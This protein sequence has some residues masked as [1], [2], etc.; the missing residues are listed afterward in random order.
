MD[1]KIVD[2]NFTE[3]IEDKTYSVT[4]A[5][6][7]LK[8]SSVKIN[9]IIFKI[10]R[11]D[12]D[13]VLIEDIN[14][15]TQS[16]LETI[17]LFETLHKDEGMSYEDVV[18]YFLKNSNNLLKKEDKTLSREITELD[19]KAIAKSLMM[20]SQKQ[21][22]MIIQTLKTDILSEIIKSFSEE[23]AK[24]GKATIEAMNI[25][26]QEIDIELEEKLSEFNNRVD[27]LTK[28]IEEKDK[29]LE[30]LYNEKYEKQDEDLRNKLNKMKNKYEEELQKEKEKTW[31][32]K[33]KDRFK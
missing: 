28:K 7:K 33:I 21:T 14:N 25:T 32:D 23:S 4:E 15:L 13:R 29:E 17:E 2:T 26:K 18:K 16:D 27:V 6:E 1:K 10:N 11:L 31:I 9:H 20:E 3:I 24:I 22:E 5:S 12:K 30:R 19:S 8:I